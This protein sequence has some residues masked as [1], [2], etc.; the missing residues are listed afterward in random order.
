MLATSLPATLTKLH[1]A[2]LDVVG[3]MNGPQRDQTIIKEAGIA[4]D[5]VLFPLLV[6]V[7]KLGPIGVV[8]LAD[9][10]GRDYTTVSRQLDKLDRLGLIQRRKASRDGRIR[11]AEITPA[12]RMMNAA[13]DAAREQLLTAAFASWNRTDVDVLAELL[14]RFANDLMG[15]P[16]SVPEPARL[17][18]TA[19]KPS[20]QPSGHARGRT[21][22][23]MVDPVD[24]R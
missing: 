18:E 12:G 19:I 23:R 16:A 1:A 13:I 3:V 9:R 14:R 15:R 8:A 7:Y 24:S 6:I 20:D 10:V 2:V 17:E 22:G 11:E 21:A 5:Q 4:L